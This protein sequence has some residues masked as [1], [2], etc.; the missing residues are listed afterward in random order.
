[1]MTFNVRLK[2]VDLVA[3][4]IAKL[5]CLQVQDNLGMVTLCSRWDLQ[6]IMLPLKPVSCLIC[7]P[8]RTA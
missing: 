2:A 5:H 3:H 7:G 4:L 6:L 8:G 1:M